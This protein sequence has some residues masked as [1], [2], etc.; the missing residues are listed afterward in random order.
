MKK[1]G[2]DPEIK[3]HIVR[4]ERDYLKLL[5]L[6]SNDFD[7]LKIRKYALKFR[8]GSAKIFEEIDI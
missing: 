3:F 4:D 8:M 5:E 6:A 1:C 7:A 2:S